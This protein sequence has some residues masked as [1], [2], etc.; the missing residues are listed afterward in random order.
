MATP[1]AA[2]TCC[3]PPASPPPA[4]STPPPQLTTATPT[5]AGPG[6]KLPGK[7][8]NVK[9]AALKRKQEKQEKAAAFNERLQAR[10]S[11]K[12]GQK[13]RKAALKALY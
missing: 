2:P 12:L 9:S 4:S 3:P 7:R 6:R 8:G 1:P 10:A 11:A 5:A 13:Q